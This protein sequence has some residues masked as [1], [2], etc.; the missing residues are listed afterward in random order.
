MSYPEPKNKLVSF[1]A[2][3]NENSVLKIS[4]SNDAM[5]EISHLEKTAWCIELRHDLNKTSPLR[6]EFT[7]QHEQIEVSP[8]N[9]SENNQFLELELSSTKETK[10]LI[11]K[12]TWQFK[13]FDETGSEI[14]VSN[15]DPFLFHK[16]PVEIYDGI[17]SLKLTDLGLLGPGLPPGKKFESSM[18]RFSY[19]LPEGIVLG[20]PGQTGEINRSGHRFEMYNTDNPTHTPETSSPL[21]QSWPILFHKDLTGNGWIAIFH[22]N[23][24]RTFVDIGSFYPDS[25]TFES[26]YGNN[27]IY[28]FHGK[29]S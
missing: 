13:V 3:S 4:D 7:S 11:D 27:R 18:L 15:T 5:L 28:I 26:S 2:S 24:S 12:S 19:P 17:K 9:V 10:L 22:D 25:I 23:P 8:L 6:Q 1:R 20:L 21:Y 14:F 16:K 29:T